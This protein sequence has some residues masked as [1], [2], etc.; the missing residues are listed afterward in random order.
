MHTRTPANCRGLSLA[1]CTTHGAS[2]AARRRALVSGTSRTWGRVRPAG[3]ASSQRA[4]TKAPVDAARDSQQSQ[5]QLALAVPGPYPA[6]YTQLRHRPQ[7]LVR[8]VPASPR[9]LGDGI[10]LISTYAGTR[11]QTNKGACRTG[12]RSA[13]ARSERRRRRAA[14]RRHRVAIGLDEKHVPEDK[15]KA[16]QAR[17]L[18][19]CPQRCIR[20]SERG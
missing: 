2:L 12:K 19:W 7:S 10:S 15:N 5:R 8:Y 18:G 14:S 9:A 11:A 3:V 6:A 20:E 13:R 1:R 17:R 4:S 16:L